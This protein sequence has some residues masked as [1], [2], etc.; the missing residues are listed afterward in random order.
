MSTFELSGERVLSNAF[1]DIGRGDV[2]KIEAFSIHDGESLRLTFE[3]VNSPWRQGVWMKTDSYVVVNGQRC[4]SIELWQGVAPNEIVIE[5]HTY[6]GCLQLYN[7]W[8]KGNGRDSQS[9]TAGMLV[10]ELPNGRRYRCNDIGFD[11]HFDK[12]I[13]RIE[14][15]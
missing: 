15:A 11:T 2:V 13:F 1:K 7:I 9:W 10:D 12:L 14:R 5:C 4:P 3:S 6:N 8:D